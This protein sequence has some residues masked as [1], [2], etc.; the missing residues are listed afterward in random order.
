MKKMQL[1]GL[2]LLTFLGSSMAT[3]DTLPLRG[4]GTFHCVADSIT[5]EPG[6]P[7]ATVTIDT[8]RV[9]VLGFCK[10]GNKINGQ[11]F[12]TVDT[13]GHLSNLPIS[14]ELSGK[15]YTLEQV[16]FHYSDANRYGGSYIKASPQS[17]TKSS[18]CYK[19]CVGD[20]IDFGT[21]NSC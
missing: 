18:T 12:G 11:S 4:N 5:T 16:C 19:G 6:S 8:T 15:T 17:N 2:A 10:D 14:I 13:E 20:H 9:K 7:V 3:A 1:A 21:G